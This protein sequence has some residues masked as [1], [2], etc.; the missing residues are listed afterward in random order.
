MFS[1]DKNE[2][3]HTIEIRIKELKFTLSYINKMTEETMTRDAR[4]ILVERK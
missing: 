4:D 2:N 1:I 3:T